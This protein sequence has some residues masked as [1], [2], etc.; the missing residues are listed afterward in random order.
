MHNGAFPTAVRKA[1][2]L[3]PRGAYETARVLTPALGQVLILVDPRNL[4]WM[5][6][7]PTREKVALPLCSKLVQQGVY[8]RTIA[9]RQGG[10]RKSASFSRPPGRIAVDCQG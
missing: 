5:T 9:L 4:I 8:L 10:G 2:T 3:R 6:H 7:V 1:A